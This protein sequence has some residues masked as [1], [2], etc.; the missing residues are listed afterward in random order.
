MNATRR[1]DFQSPPERPI[2]NRPCEER[3]TGS[4]PYSRR[5][6]IRYGALGGIVLLSAGLIVR[7]RQARESADCPQNPGCHGC[8]ALAE[9]GLP[10]AVKAR[11]SA[12]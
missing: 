6:A 3:P 7:G 12:L 9:C 8:A 4:R 10:Q 2:E 1:G 5:E 11:E